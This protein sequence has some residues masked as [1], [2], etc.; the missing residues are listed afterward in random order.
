MTLCQFLQLWLPMITWKWE[1]YFYMNNVCLAEQD[2]GL[3]ICSGNNLCFHLNWSAQWE[4]FAK[5]VLNLLFD[6]S[7]S[8]FIEFVIFWVAF[9]YVSSWYI[10]VHS[11][12][13]YYYYCWLAVI[14]NY[15]Y[16]IRIQVSCIKEKILLMS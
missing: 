6:L 14:C 5:L 10:C 9:C 1:K 3:V 16:F 7:N 8:Q 2:L 12:E 13:I 15:Q 11:F 4:L